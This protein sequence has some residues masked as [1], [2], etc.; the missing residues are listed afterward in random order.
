MEKFVL[1]FMSPIF[2]IHSLFPH[3]VRVI[4]RRVLHSLDANYGNVPTQRMKK[5]L[6]YRFKLLGVRCKADQMKSL[7]FASLVSRLGVPL[8]RERINC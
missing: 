5:L 1:V 2:Q 4:H 8:I 7:F 6:L 3:R